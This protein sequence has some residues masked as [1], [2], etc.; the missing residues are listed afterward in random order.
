M[1]ELKFKFFFISSKNLN[2]EI[3]K[4]QNES[5]ISTIFSQRDSAVILRH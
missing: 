5:N 1:I 4:H 2:I 3:K